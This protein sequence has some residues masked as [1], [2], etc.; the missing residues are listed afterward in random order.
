MAMSCW[1]RTRG[2]KG[3]IPGFSDNG[4]SRYF[5]KQKIFQENNGRFE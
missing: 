5:D 4:G 2:R 3:Q 1:V